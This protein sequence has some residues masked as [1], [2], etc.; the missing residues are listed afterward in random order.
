MRTTTPRKPMSASNEAPVGAWVLWE[1]DKPR[2]MTGYALALISR[3]R[4]EAYGLTDSDI[5]L[6]APD[7]FRAQQLE[8][9]F[10]TLRAQWRAECGISSSTTKIILAPSYQ[11]II[12][13]GRAAVPLIMRHLEKGD[14][15]AFWSWALQSITGAKPFRDEDKGKVKVLAQAWLAWWRENKDG[16]QLA[17][18]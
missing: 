17:A 6:S 1:A 5:V 11:R 12:G 4:S 9:Q 7:E 14:Q 10:E 2:E 8:E 13:M 15:P 18:R 3:E 16:W